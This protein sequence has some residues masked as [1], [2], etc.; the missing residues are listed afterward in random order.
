MKFKKHHGR[1]GKKHYKGG[2]KGKGHSIRTYRM[3]RGGIKM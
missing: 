3:K 1:A 2:R